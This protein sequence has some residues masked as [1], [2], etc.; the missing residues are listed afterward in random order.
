MSRS[1]TVLLAA[2]LVA[3]LTQV[4][5]AQ[6][7]STTLHSGNGAA[8]APDAVVR[9]FIVDDARVLTAQDFTS[10]RAAPFSR[11]IN[12]CC[13]F[14]LLSSD[15]AA[16]YI[17]DNGSN[18]ASPRVLYA[19]DFNIA[20]APV[21]A[22][23]AFGIAT[24]DQLG[25]NGNVGLYL[26]GQP[27]PGSSSGYTANSPGYFVYENLAGLLQ[28]GTNTLYLYYQNSGGGPGMTVFSGTFNLSGN[29][30]VSGP[31]CATALDV[32]VST[33]VPAILRGSNGGNPTV[34]VNACRGSNPVGPGAWYRFTGDGK[35]ITVSTCEGTNTFDTSISVFC[36]PCG[37]NSQMCVAANDD[38]CGNGGSR[39]TFCTLAGNTYYVLVTG[40][41]S[42]IGTFDLTFL[43]SGTACT[44]A[45]ACTPCTITIPVAAI[46]ENEPACGTNYNDNFNAGCFSTPPRYSQ[47]APGQTIA[48]KAGTFVRNGQDFRDTDWYEFTLTQPA[49]VLLIARAEFPFQLGLIDGRTACAS[50]INLNLG[51]VRSPSC[52]D[53]VIRIVL[54]AGRFIAFAAPSALSG[55]RCDSNYIL[56]L[57]TTP[58]GRCDFSSGC[59]LVTSATCAAA[60]G[61]Y[62]GDNTSCADVGYVATVLPFSFEDISASGAAITFSNADDGGAIIVPG[63]AF[64]Y[65]GS[66]YTQIG[67]STNGYL[68]FGTD[69]LDFPLPRAMPNTRRPNNIIAAR[70]SNLNLD[71]ATPSVPGAGT[72]KWQV[73][74]ASPTR[75]LIVQWTGVPQF[76]F[77]DTN[78]FQAA[79]FE[80]DGS[81]EFRYQLVQP[82]AFNGQVVAGVE[83]IDGTR[84]TNV[85]A[86]QVTS[87]TRV[88][89]RKGNLIAPVAVSGGPYALSASTTSFNASA[90][91]SNDPDGALPGFAGIRS[92]QWD[93]GADG[94]SD[95]AARINGQETFTLAQALAKGLTL[96]NPVPL[97]LSVTDFSNLIA[98]DQTFIIYQNT[99][100]TVVSS[101]PFGPIVP[102]GQAV[103]GGT[104]TDP[105]QLLAVNEQF[106]IEWATRR[107]T[108]AAD[109]GTSSTFATGLAPTVS[110]ATFLNLANSTGTTI[111]LNVKDRAGAIASVST[112]FSINLPDITP[113]TPT[114]PT[115][116]A[117]GTTISVTMPLSNIG[118][119][120]ATGNW[121]DRVY[122]STDATLSGDD[123]YLGDFS[124]TANNIAPGSIVTR[125]YSLNLPVRFASGLYRV[126]VTADIFNQLPETSESN[127]TVASGVMSLSPTPAADLAVTTVSAP[128]DASW[129]QPID[130]SFIVT[131]TGD[132]AATGPFVDGIFI[133]TQPNL[134]GATA[135]TTA[136]GPLSLAVNDTYSRTLSV[137]TP[138]NPTG[139]GNWYIVVRTD[140]GGSV[141]EPD[142][143]NNVRASGIVRMEAT[144]SV[145]LTV[146]SASAPS[147]GV[148]GRPIDVQWTVRNTGQAAATGA[149]YDR[150]VLRNPA[151]GTDIA[152]GDFRHDGPLAPTISYTSS[153]IVRLPADISGP[154][155]ICVITDATNTVSEPQPGAET[156]NRTC[157]ASTQVALPNGAD[158]VATSVGIFP[159]NPVFG[160]P[161]T[162]VYTLY[163][164]GNA[165]ATGIWTDRLW[166]SRD[167]TLSADDISLSF[168]DGTGPLDASASADRSVGI[169]LPLSAALTSGTYYAIAVVDA[170]AAVQERLENNNVTVSAP[171]TINRPTLPNLQALSISAPPSGSPGQTVSISWQVRNTSTVATTAPSNW[172]ERIVASTDGTTD[173]PLLALFTNTTAIPPL[174]TITRNAT[175]TIP[176]LGT[177]YVLK[178]CVD[179]GN[180]LL[181]SVETDNCNVSGPA[182]V[183]RPDL[184]VNDLAVPAT[185]VADS[186]ISITYT[187]A[188]VGAAATTGA[189][190]EN[191]H[192]VSIATGAD[193]LLDSFLVTPQ[194]PAAG[195]IA[196]TRSLIIP[197]RLEGQYLF[198]VITDATDTNIESGPPANNIRTAASTTIITQPTRGNLVATAV[199]P[200][201]TGLVGS[202]GSITY[203]VQ[204]IGSVPAGPAWADRVIAV[205]TDAVGE[206]TLSDVPQ[207][208][209]LAAGETRSRTVSFSYP[210]VAG[211]YRI[212]V[213][214][215][216][217]DSVY[218]GAAGETDNVLNSPGTFLAETFTVTA[219]A[220][221]TSAVSGTPVIITG[222]ARTTGG[223]PV[224]STPIE[225][226]VQVQ[227]TNREI[228]R[229]GDLPVVTD[230]QGNYTVTF[231]P[232][233]TEGGIYTVL[234]GPRGAVPNLARD[235]F[236]MY[237]LNLPQS[238]FYTT[239][240]SAAPENISIPLV[241][242]CD[243][244]ITGVTANVT[245]DASD[246]VISLTTAPTILAGQTGSVN[247]N[248]TAVTGMVIRR[249]LQVNI[250]TAQGNVL[251]AFV[252]IEA[253]PLQPTLV[254]TPGSLTAQVIRG[255]QTLISFR[256][257]NIGAGAATNLSLQLPGISWVTA[258]NGSIPDLA[259]GAGIDLTIRLAPPDTQPLSTATGNIAVANATGTYGVNIPYS[260]R[261]VS[262]RLTSLIIRVEDERSFYDATGAYIPSGGPMVDNAVVKLRDSITG[263]VLFQSI[264]SRPSGGGDVRAATFTDIPEQLYN[265]TVEAE[266]HGN[267]SANVLVEEDG[268][269]SFRVFIPFQAVRFNWIVQNTTVTE[270]TII[271]LEAVYET[272]VPAPVITI[273]PPLIDLANYPSG[274]QLDVTITNHGLVA[275]E[276]V[277]I[278]FE[279]NPRWRLTPLVNQFGRLGPNQSRTIPVTIEKLEGPGGP[280]SNCT[281]T[282]GV[283]YALVCIGRNLYSIPIPVINVSGDC[284]GGV[285]GGGGWGGWGGGGGWGGFGGG[286]GGGGGGFGASGNFTYPI[287]TTNPPQCRQ[288]DP[289]TFQEQCYS[290]S[291]EAD[292][293][294]Y[295]GTLISAVTAAFP[296]LDTDVNFTVN[297]EG[298]ICT[299]C[300]PDGGISLKARGNATGSLT[301][302]LS[303][304]GNDLALPGSYN[305]NFNV[306]GVSVPVAVSFRARAGCELLRVTGTLSASGESE[307]GFGEPRICVTGS[308]EL[309]P[310]GSCSLSATMTGTV[311]GGQYAGYVFT[312]GVGATIESGASLSAS[313]SSCQTPPYNLCVKNDIKLKILLPTGVALTNAQGQSVLGDIPSPEFEFQLYGPNC[314][315][316]GYDCCP[317]SP[318]SIQLPPPPTQVTGGWNL[319]RYI[320]RGVVR[321]ADPPEDG[322]GLCAQVGIQLAQSV[323]ITRTAVSCTLEIDNTLST[324]PVENFRV[325]LSVFDENGVDKTSLFGISTL[326]TLQGVTGVTGTGVVPSGRSA[327]ASWIVLPTRDAAPQF[328]KRYF[329]GGYVSYIQ[330]GAPRSFV[331]T[332]TGLTV[333]PDPRIQI[334]YFLQRDVYSDDPFTPEVEPSEPFSLGIM[335]TNS[336]YGTAGNVNIT[337]SQPRIVQNGRDLLIDFQIIASQ[338]G[339]QSVAP[340]LTMN[341]GDIPPQTTTVGRYILTT[342]LLGHF[343]DFSATY[344]RRD[345]YG[346]ANDRVA[347]IDSVTTYNLIHCVKDQRAA[348][349]NLP[350]FLTDELSGL[351]DP[352][353]NPDVPILRQLPDRVHLSDGTVRSV[354]S[355]LTATL[356]P[357]SADRYRMQLAAPT[358]FFYSNIADPYNATLR[359]T[360][361][362][363][364]DGRELA[365]GYNFWQTDRV[366]RDRQQPLRDYRIH[367]FDNDGT[368]DYTFYFETPPASPLIDSWNVQA[369]H[370]TPPLAVSLAA[371]GDNDLSDPRIGGPQRLV[372]TSNSQLNPS[373][374]SAGNI[375]LVGR[376]IDGG[377]VDLSGI[378]FTTSLLPGGRGGVITFNSPLPRKVRYCMNLVAVT[379]GLGRFVSGQTRVRFNTIAGDS[380]GD[381]QVNLA[382]IST[383][384]YRLG[385]VITDPNDIESARCDINRDGVVDEAD[386]ALVTAA[387]GIDMRWIADPCFGLLLGNGGDP[388]ATQPPPILTYNELEPNNTY[389]SATRAY[390]MTY[391]DRITGNSQGIAAGNGPDSSDLFRVSSAALPAGIYRHRLQLVAGGPDLFST[392]LLGR[393]QVGRV[394]GPFGSAVLQQLTPPI[395]GLHYNQFYDFGGSG[396]IAYT[397]SGTATTTA[398]YLVTV[399]TEPVS[400]VPIG[401]YRSGIVTIS[402]AG[403]G[404]TT[405][406]EIILYNG[407]FFPVAGGRNDDAG[408]TS[409]NRSTISP[410]LGPGTY[411][412]AISDTNTADDQPNLLGDF[413]PARPV[414]DYR[415]VLVNSS[416]S[417]NL[418]LNYSISSD[419]VSNQIRAVKPERYGIYFAVFTVT[420]CVADLVG[421]GIPIPDGIVD[422]NDFIAFFNAYAAGDVLAD[423]AGPGASGPPDGIIDGDDFI[424]FI[425]AYSA[426][427]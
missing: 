93:L 233:P 267:Y 304:P 180:E 335:L 178:L 277:G 94:I 424:A 95:D 236:V 346:I 371:V 46:A 416:T 257:E 361:V 252:N 377:I 328:E 175:I 127:N 92:V 170:G 227:G 341:F 143:N 78:T 158:L 183:N 378:S 179:A 223:S 85:A 151:D 48:G 125:S 176:N 50:T 163:N 187:T 5:L 141:L 271:T 182:V 186:T 168:V 37:G 206:V 167:E 117:F 42:A 121:S 104:I 289:N 134:S 309:A 70:W 150:V 19:V 11:V 382:D 35:P 374:F 380:T 99:A 381:R 144:N 417:S 4:S 60:G 317:E 398:D 44:D 174:T 166:L 41:S 353:E 348:A 23:L 162:I 285:G 408:G 20:F 122:L 97:R 368:G 253:R 392:A 79:L 205:R 349:D 274:G 414:T 171:I 365:L 247:L 409:G 148:A 191:V 217:G 401:E 100:P 24:D 181:E 27:I 146:A 202:T 71:P 303:T 310:L 33:T 394:P 32:P 107:Y 102:A 242:P 43:R 321:A 75:R 112:T 61:T 154:R 255:G 262:Q 165:P 279:S 103:L 91:A 316:V 298:Q 207:V 82:A 47:I 259:G 39:V 352:N 59:T 18:N 268:D 364:S 214:V 132:T 373:S 101:G 266:R 342:T 391:R 291:F 96:T 345:D 343:V 230:A 86:G 320:G 17:N 160:S 356:T 155:T 300:R 426:G 119:G 324:T 136:A 218:E 21:I 362:V 211:T 322:N 372:F 256:L 419:S 111:W 140:N 194:I 40:F 221:I 412:L 323:A 411:F 264:T 326:P 228:R 359:L 38:D 195:T 369:N 263:D 276:D 251:T 7:T 407:E 188:N 307:C 420:G 31:T 286:G 399:K 173:G 153:Q 126:I 312:A 305:L 350:D 387:A 404:H 219:D 301:I 270:V 225:V 249:S 199:Q 192:F 118:G 15:P 370:G 152:L 2:M 333:R 116:A 290:R 337:S 296:G 231:N 234:A 325:E 57:A 248:V 265:I 220:D 13:S 216:R 258:T 87:N 340:S 406:T 129:G 390:G 421:A 403:Q 327:R 193:T 22:T 105:D 315:S 54:P 243:V 10:A 329:F 415:G 389:P 98:N 379:D 388:T 375:S 128:T 283:R 29:T 113:G 427:C 275:A 55:V 66:L 237:A 169:T 358:G 347:I 422:G 12:P 241:N 400:P 215:D 339:A 137:A 330:S 260:F 9:A 120:A 161:A 213:I 65:F 295:I 159:A 51:D 88:A 204:N 363:R 246:L 272:F 281:L 292:L 287:T 203:T 354:R 209:T 133:N 226:R 164:I 3:S 185:A 76:G 355:I 81:I 135:L 288:C 410:L 67:V 201:A 62:V 184:T 190:L 284:G 244:A 376:A 413:A 405:D 83:N 58:V 28:A 222:Q 319:P 149:W 8:G 139:A 80:G 278:N 261:V 142:E 69:D 357:Q 385:T 172:L 131:N 212:R 124:F 360:R 245:G 224:P 425:N 336:G 110:Y 299:C 351:D 14:Q 34:A 197:T 240:Q 198:K 114:V 72:V 254:V 64:T 115:S 208:G 396:E 200:I 56:S 318:G 238:A 395:S 366:F 235:S 36:G 74:G 147:T 77:T 386:L 108:A 123:S 402:T 30:P 418:P 314:A 89:L 26:N 157:A 90:L 269:P 25:G 232:V 6:F 156:D 63:F 84:G 311:T 273:S 383:V 239:I 145:N 16:L 332:P 308:A 306:G 293:N 1:A 280:E 250:T 210:S 45:P 52:T 367:L 196:Q 302:T 73:L 177:G 138:V 338:I 334:K 397:L 109:F 53:A 49:E 393:T 294:G 423:V 68:R 331:L 130:I 384:R 189:F 297:G 313:I 229:P 282:A 344:R 106:T